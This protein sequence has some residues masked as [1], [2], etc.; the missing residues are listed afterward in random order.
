MADEPETKI[1]VLDRGHV[2]VGRIVP[3]PT[4]AF[5]WLV[6]PGRTIRRW[7]TDQGL[8]QLA[9]GPLAD[10]VLDAI[11]TFSVPWRAVLFLIDVKE[12]AWREFLKLGVDTQTTRRR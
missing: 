9:D 5:H 8:P 4:L 10:T 7:G 11:G 12:E 2:L 3:H 6:S 1:L